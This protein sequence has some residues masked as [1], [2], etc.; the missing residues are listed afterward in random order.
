MNTGERAERWTA[1]QYII[2]NSMPIHFN[3]EQNQK[4]FTLIE[5]LIVIAIISILAAVVFVALDPLTRFQDARDSSRWNDATA[6]LSAIKI[7]QVDNGGAYLWAVTN[8]SAATNYM[9]S[10]ATTTTG[11]NLTC[12]AAATSTSNC[13]N[14][15]GLVSEGYVG[16]LPVSSNG[17]GNWSSIYTGYYMNKSS[18]G[19]I[20]VGACESENTTAI[21]VTR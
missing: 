6:L 9:I 10:N 3:R 1:S 11:C 18:A 2:K 19:I 14:L 13:V 21:S 5:L 16:S 20:T 8:A 12:D 4:G 15:Q 17:T 7:D